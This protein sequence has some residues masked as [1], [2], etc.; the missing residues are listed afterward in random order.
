MLLAAA[1]AISCSPDRQNVHTPGGDAT[2]TQ[3][4]KNKGT[5]E[6]AK[7]GGGTLTAEYEAKQIPADWPKDVPLLKDADPVMALKSSAGPQLTVM[8]AEPIPAI[9]AFYEAQLPAHDWKID[10]NRSTGNE[11]R[12]TAAKGS[13]TAIVSALDRGSRRQVTI[14][15]LTR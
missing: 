8:T 7:P 13:Q 15:V 3:T 1:A 5:V 10:S 12:L 9:V 4:G 2:V 11:A 6:M 14:N